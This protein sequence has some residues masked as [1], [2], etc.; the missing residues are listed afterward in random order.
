MV[1]VVC[2]GKKT[3]IKKSG[4]P[5]NIVWRVSARIEAQILVPL[6]FLHHP[7]YWTIRPSV[8][9]LQISFFHLSTHIHPDPFSSNHTR[10]LNSTKHIVMFSATFVLLHGPFPQPQRNFPLCPSRQLPFIL[11]TYLF[12]KTFPKISP[13][14]VF[15]LY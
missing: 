14:L 4:I 13:T 15:R 1:H 10:K 7:F 9:D 3:K 12:F 2:V 5:H 11:K 8:I 6:F